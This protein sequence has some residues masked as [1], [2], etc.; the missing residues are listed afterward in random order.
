MVARANFGGFVRADE[1]GGAGEVS[2]AAR[3]RTRRLP[4]ARR[5][6]SFAGRLVATPPDPCPG[7]TDDGR[8]MTKREIMLDVIAKSKMHK[9]VRELACM[10]R[11]VS[12]VV[13]VMHVAD[14]TE[15]S[16]RRCVARGGP[17]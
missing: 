5:L 11:H 1:E 7:Q 6:M 8:P 13:V 12:V 16:V 2:R 4:D 10:H 9:V 15:L 14:R 17:M 3:I